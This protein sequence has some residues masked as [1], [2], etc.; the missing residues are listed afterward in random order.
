LKKNKNILIIDDSFTNNV[1]IEAILEGEGYKIDKAYTVTEALKVV[2]AKKIELILLDL[3][4]PKRN[5]YDFLRSVKKNEKTKDIPVMIVSAV[6][7][8]GKINKTYDLGA[9][10]YVSK[11]INIENFVDKVNNM[12]LSK[13]MN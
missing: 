5:G 8:P 13:V 12:L 10:D 11:P 4:M 7:D 1:L 6:T 3:I 2:K 9:I